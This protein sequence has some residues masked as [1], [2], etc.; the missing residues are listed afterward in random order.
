MPRM[1]A[2]SRIGMSEGGPGSVGRGQINSPSGEL[3]SAV[4]AAEPFIA[5][6]GE[7]RGTDPKRLQT[8]RSLGWHIV[9]LKHQPLVARQRRSR[10]EAKLG[11]KVCNHVGHMHD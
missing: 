10:Q 5:D 8:G 3:T 9:A 2:I 4:K 7:R 6:G 1:I 11:Q